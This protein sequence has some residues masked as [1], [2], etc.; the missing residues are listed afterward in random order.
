MRSAATANHFNAAAGHL[1]GRA[2][3]DDLETDIENQLLN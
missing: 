2:G 3:S 1:I